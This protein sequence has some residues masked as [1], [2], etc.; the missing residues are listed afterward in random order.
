MSQTKENLRTAEMK[1]VP[2]ILL[3]LFFAGCAS[4]PRAPQEE[5][6]AA[7]AGIDSRIDTASIEDYILALPPFAYHEESVEGFASQVRRARASER[8]NAGRG[9]DSLF[10]RGDGTWP[11]KEFFL[12]RSRRLLAIR[13]LHWEPGTAD[14][15]E[16]MRRVPGGWMRGR[17]IGAMSSQVKI[18]PGNESRRRSVRAFGTD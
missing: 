3:V 11:A 13:I 14:E 17:G 10:V 8:E 1:L 5:F 16:T 15:Y 4:S 2:G 12:D 7:P 6:A 18:P 9:P